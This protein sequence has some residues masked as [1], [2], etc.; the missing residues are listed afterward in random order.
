MEK[1]YKEKLVLGINFKEAE[2]VRKFLNEINLLDKFYRPFKNDKVYFPLKEKMSWEEIV[3]LKSITKN[4]VLTKKKVLERKK[5]YQLHECIKKIKN[6]HKFYLNPLRY[7]VLGD[8]IL[9]EIKEE[10]P[11]LEKD[12]IELILLE[13]KKV[14]AIYK[15]KNL[16]LIYKGI[17][18]EIIFGNKREV[19][20]NENYAVFLFDI[21]EYIIDPRLMWERN[22][23]LNE[24]TKGEKIAEINTKIGLNSI[25]IAKKIGNQ[26]FAFEKNKNLYKYLVENIKRNKVEKIV[27]PILYYDINYIVQNYR[28][29]FDRIIIYDYKESLNLIEISCELIKNKGGNINLL[30]FSKEETFE[31]ISK[32]IKE[33]IERK[34]RNIK[35]FN[36]KKILKLFIQEN[37]VKCNIEIE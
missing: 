7:L 8:V 13:R 6:T 15:I 11:Q 24:I 1:K 3:K 20:Y 2:K 12:I 27:K 5:L 25:L 28:K 10:N 22:E 9:I 4:F 33:K 36:I 32:I 23:L 19:V 30:T 26:I 14:T 21:K 37:L 29:K 35:K 31:D 34:K 16:N 18:P 17:I